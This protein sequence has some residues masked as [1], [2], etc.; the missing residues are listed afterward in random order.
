M[1]EKIDSGINKAEEFYDD[2]VLL[3]ENNRFTSA[4]TRA[5]YSM[6]KIVQV[7][8]LSQNL[9][10]KTH[11]GLQ[12]K[13]QEHFIKPQIFDRRYSRILISA[14]ELRQLSDYDNAIEISEE[15]A[16]ALLK[17]AREL[18]DTIKKHLARK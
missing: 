11:K 8:L 17:D 4:T 14:Y 2:A 16:H 18:I 9:F 15:D 13:F 7:L 10:T 1:R 6:F 5:Y 3:I 12:I